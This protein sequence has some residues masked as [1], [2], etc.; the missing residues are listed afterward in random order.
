MG[1][2]FPWGCLSAVVCGKNG[3]RLL[4]LLQGKL[5]EAKTDLQAAAQRPALA[6]L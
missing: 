5:A 6:T 4:L 1:T 2:S 3:D